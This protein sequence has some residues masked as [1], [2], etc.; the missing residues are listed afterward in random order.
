MLFRSREHAHY[1]AWNSSRVFSEKA[2]D[3]SFESRTDSCSQLRAANQQRPTSGGIRNRM[4]RM[5]SSRSIGQSAA[6]QATVGAAT[7]FDPTPGQRPPSPVTKLNV[8]HPPHPVPNKSTFPCD[9]CKSQSAVQVTAIRNPQHEAQNEI[10][11]RAHVRSSKSTPAMRER[12]NLAPSEISMAPAIPQLPAQHVENART[13]IFPHPVRG[14]PGVP[15]NLKEAKDKRLP[16]S[17]RDTNTQPQRSGGCDDREKANA[18]TR[19]PGHRKAASVSHS[20]TMVPELAHLKQSKHSSVDAS[21]LRAHHYV[22]DHGTEKEHLTITLT[23]VRS[24]MLLRKGSCL[25]ESGNIRDSN[26]LKSPLQRL[27]SFGKSAGE[28]DVL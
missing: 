10:S 12:V 9:E 5:C 20:E 3:A 1:R 24:E 26:G 19:L 21:R 13:L 15:P 11:R 23:R 16:L 4:K 8:P 18:T 2:Q 17:E 25:F 14:E 27:E 7:P 28:M 22:Q 6:F